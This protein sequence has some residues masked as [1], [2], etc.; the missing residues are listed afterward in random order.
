MTRSLGRRRGRMTVRFAM[1]RNLVRR[2]VARANVARSLGRRG[3]MAVRFAMRNLIGSCVTQLYVARSISGGWTIAGR[4]SV[5]GN[6]IKSC[7]AGS[8]I[9]GSFGRRRCLSW[10]FFRGRNMSKS[11]SSGRN[12]GGGNDGDESKSNNATECSELHE[13]IS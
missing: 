1:R 11:F 2:C 3:S 13:C 10:N 7:V 5:W 12:P 4:F 9:P 6:I 8:N